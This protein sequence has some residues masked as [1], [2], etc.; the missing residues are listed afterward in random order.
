MTIQTHAL[1]GGASLTDPG[2][3]VGGDE[4]IWVHRVAFEMLDGAIVGPALAISSPRS[5]ALVSPH[6]EKQ[7]NALRHMQPIPATE[8]F[9]YAGDADQ[10]AL[11]EGVRR[12]AIVVSF[13]MHP[14]ISGHTI[15]DLPY[16]SLFGAASA[17]PMVLHRLRYRRPC[18]TRFFFG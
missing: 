10:Q 11:C 3:A 4:R 8:L 13:Q 1:P 2:Q 17:I 18:N 5:A 6:P 9:E 7:S 16:T 15:D 12:A 14:D